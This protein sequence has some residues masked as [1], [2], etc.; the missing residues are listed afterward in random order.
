MALKVDLKLS[1]AIKGSNTP[2]LEWT[3]GF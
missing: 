1:K 3:G 2:Q